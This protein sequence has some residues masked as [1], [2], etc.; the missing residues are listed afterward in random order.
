MDPRTHAA[1]A[2]LLNSGEPAIRLMARRDLLGEPAG[3]ARA[4]C[5]PAPR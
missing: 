4:R 1:V 5:W 2:W 3:E